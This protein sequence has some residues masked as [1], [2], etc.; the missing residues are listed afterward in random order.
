MGNEQLP[1]SL[2]LQITPKLGIHSKQVKQT[3]ECLITVVMIQCCSV[4][5]MYSQLNFGC[6]CIVFSYL[7]PN[8]ELELGY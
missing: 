2:L 3:R 6:G 5:S 7:V 1:L 8:I 4:A